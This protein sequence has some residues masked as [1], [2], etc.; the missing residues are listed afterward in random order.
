MIKHKSIEFF[1]KNHQ[2]L[3]SWNSYRIDIA[4]LILSIIFAIQFTIVLI[5]D[6]FFH[7]ILAKI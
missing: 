6:Q 4:F 1:L 7:D 2:V 3:I 5:L